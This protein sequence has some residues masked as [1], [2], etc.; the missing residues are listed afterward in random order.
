M[1]LN[2]PSGQVYIID[3]IITCFS[4]RSEKG[5]NELMRI[6]FHLQHLSD[7]T[8]NVRRSMR[9][10]MVCFPGLAAHD[11]IQVEACQYATRVL[12]VGQAIIKFSI[13]EVHGLSKQWVF[14]RRH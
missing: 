10:L 11:L 1:S 12:V 4:K 14:R 3:A 8:L 6:G 13:Q 2:V 9:K 5:V 7:R